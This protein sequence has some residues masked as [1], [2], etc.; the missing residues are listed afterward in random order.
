M[1][2]NACWLAAVIENPQ[3]MRA[4]GT[5]IIAQGDVVGPITGYRKATARGEMG[6]IVMCCNAGHVRL[7]FEREI[8]Q[9]V[10]PRRPSASLKVV[11]G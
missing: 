9:A 11:S 1:S 7:V 6:Y 3:P 8:V 2:S 5:V 4:I 10:A